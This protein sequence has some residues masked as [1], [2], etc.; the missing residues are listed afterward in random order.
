MRF[1]QD[2][3]ESALTLSLPTSARR[4]TYASLRGHGGASP[5]LPTR[6]NE[7]ALAVWARLDLDRHVVP[8]PGGRGSPDCSE[9]VQ[10][11]PD[12]LRPAHGG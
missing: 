10:T 5:P 12:R 8:H 7:H 4:S 1:T 11:A 3:Y 9:P 6:S 2:V